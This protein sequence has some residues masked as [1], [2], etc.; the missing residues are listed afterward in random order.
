MQQ[1]YLVAAEDGKRLPI[2]GT[3]VIGRGDEADIYL[4]DN[5]VSRRHVEVQARDNGYYWRDLGSTN[6]TLLN[7]RSMREGRLRAEDVLQ[8]GN[9][10]F[11]FD[12]EELA[13]ANDA[14]TNSGALFQETLLDAAG[15]EQPAPPPSK[16]AILLNAVYRVVNTI[17]ANY[18]PCDL[19]DQILETMNGAIDAHRGAVF[20][21]NS[22]Y[23]LLPCPECDRVHSIQSGVLQP[24]EHGSIHISQSIARR[25]LEHGESVLYQVPT[26]SEDDAA[27]SESI[28]SLKL[29]SVLCVPLR[30]KTDILGILYFDTDRP[31]H[32]YTE[33]DRLLVSAVGNSAGL[34]LENARMHLHM[35]EK[36]RIEQDIAT[37][38]S[39]QEGFLVKDWPEDDPRF[40]VYG[41]TRPAKTVGGD[42]YDFVRP[43]LDCIGLL[44]GDVSGKGV[45]ASLMMA[46]LVAEFRLL[47]REL[48]YP[49][50][51]LSE[52]NDRL[53]ARAQRGMFCT[54]CY[55]RLDL[56]TGHL[57]CANAGHHAVMRF[58]Q[59]LAE[60]LF[61]ASGIPAG[62]MADQR[63]MDEENQL[64]V[65]D[66]LL[67]FTD[68]ITEARK[69]T[70][71]PD[72][73]P[74]EYGEVSLEA[75]G[76]A[77]GNVPLQ[78]MLDGMLDDVQAFTAPQHPHDDCTALAVRYR[79]NR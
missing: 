5:A 45:P 24:A 64:H 50:A 78:I 19:L 4:D 28:L 38:W 34:A 55:L 9:T 32:V 22:D 51:V 65:G 15:R 27:V 20:L 61:H 76:L 29:R 74:Q 25:V 70:D 48:P 1:G 30:A 57:L 3:L 35:L 12:L 56:T 58:S 8:I 69:P 7:Q 18:E 13:D 53:V 33:E 2:V 31:G 14:D 66:V 77:W 16:T 59:G 42:F 46:Q 71:S 36:Q 41:A 26:E 79:G 17:A 62:V 6:G 23:E 73:A 52:L 40:E 47:A 44:I 63:W 68:G 75:A 67:M 60:P 39:I 37:A 43:D 72:A 10:E 21:A 49:S 54:L 11:R